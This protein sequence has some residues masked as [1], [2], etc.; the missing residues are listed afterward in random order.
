V[1]TIKNGLASGAKGKAGHVYYRTLDGET[2]FSSLPEQYHTP[3]DPE[4][5]NKMNSTRILSKIG[6]LVTKEALIRSTWGEGTAPKGKH[7]FNRFFSYN[8]P[9]QEELIIPAIQ[10]VPINS[11]FNVSVKGTEVYENELTVTLDPIGTEAGIDP[12]REPLITMRGIFLLQADNAD[13][14]IAPAMEILKNMK[15]IPINLEESLMFT[16]SVINY[17]EFKDNP[18]ATLLFSVFSL[19]STGQPVKHSVTAY[20]NAVFSPIEK[21]ASKIKSEVL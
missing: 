10:I 6:S 9:K 11:G 1:A 4:S 20:C 16:C 7:P 19:S 2:V 21:I 15:A 13:V 3:T 18:N 5:V 17:R 14:S 12:I 8:H